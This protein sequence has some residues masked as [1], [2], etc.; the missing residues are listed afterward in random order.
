MGEPCWKVASNKGYPHLCSGI[1]HRCPLLNSQAV[2]KQSLQSQHL[3][4]LLVISWLSA[5]KQDSC[6]HIQTS[7]PPNTALTFHLYSFTIS[8]FTNTLLH[9]ALSASEAL[10]SAFNCQL[11]HHLA[12]ETSA[13]QQGILIHNTPAILS[14][15]LLPPPPILPW[16]NHFP[17]FPRRKKECGRKKMDL[18]GK[19]TS[20][21]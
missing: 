12:H 15:F 20:S 7:P 16:G 8:S 10:A 13:Q 9:F 5:S 14:P 17:S 19:I 11:L 1:C 4:R 21:C 2:P 3:A 18:E 6:L